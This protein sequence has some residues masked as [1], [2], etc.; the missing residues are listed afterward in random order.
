MWNGHVE[1]P[2]LI[3]NKKRERETLL[4]L[5]QQTLGGVGGGGVQWTLMIATNWYLLFVCS[6]AK[7]TNFIL[8][9][10]PPYVN[11]VRHTECCLRP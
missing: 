1:S 9:F 3:Q 6:D 10:S 11:N 4:D 5:G 2:M 7:T 8:S